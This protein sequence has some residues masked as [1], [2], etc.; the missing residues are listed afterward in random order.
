MTKLH[1][2]NGA[3]VGD[4]LL[5]GTNK[6]LV[7]VMEYENKNPQQESALRLEF[8]KWLT[9]IDVSTGH[10]VMPGVFFGA[11]SSYHD[12]S[13][14]YSAKIGNNGVALIPASSVLNVNLKL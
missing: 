9:L 5:V 3:K 1:M 11:E 10:Q 14:L 12:V 8:P 2:I 4:W 13:R 6:W 7:V